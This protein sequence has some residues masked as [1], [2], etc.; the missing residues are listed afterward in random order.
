MEGR[1]I[2][3]FIH[4]FELAHPDIANLPIGEVVES[5]RAFFIGVYVRYAEHL[6]GVPFDQIPADQKGTLGLIV[7][8]FS[9]HA[10]L[11]EAWDI[12]IPSHREPQ[13]ARQICGPGNFIVA[14]FASF[15]PIE[16]YIMGYDRGLLNE[17]STFIEGLL[18]R[19]LAAEEI[20][21]FAPIREKYSYH[22][23]L[24]SMPIQVGMDYVRFLVQLAIQHYRFASPHPVVGG[25]AKLGVVT[26]KEENFRLLE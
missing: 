14:W 10:F 3:S 21:R 7:G 23:M 4:E 12:Q 17:T 15:A 24:D 20:E 18:G 11:S 2:G 1:S 25:K 8:G 16:R 9:P 5:L 13:S 6:F 26:Y 19:P 22:I